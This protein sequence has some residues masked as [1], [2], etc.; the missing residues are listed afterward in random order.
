[1]VV[2][3]GECLIK[4]N[5]NPPPKNGVGGGSQPPPAP[6]RQKPP[7]ANASK[8]RGYVIKGVHNPGNNR[9]RQRNGELGWTGTQFHLRYCPRVFKGAGSSAC[10]EGKDGCFVWI[11]VGGEKRYGK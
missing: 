2:P 10:H 6:A 9:G 7:D 4:T 5:T 11:H 1:M 3:Q 8:R